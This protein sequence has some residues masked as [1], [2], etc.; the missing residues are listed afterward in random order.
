MAAATARRASHLVIRTL[1][2]PAARSTLNLKFTR[3]CLG[4]PSPLARL[5]SRP[6]RGMSSSTIVAKRHPASYPIMRNRKSTKCGRML[7]S[8]ALQYITSL[9]MTLEKT[10]RVVDNPKGKQMYWYYL[11]IHLNPTKR[12]ESGY[13]ATW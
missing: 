10:Q 9:R 13:N 7:I 5:I 1:I 12:R 2:S 8:L 6:A 3:S 11:P 4:A